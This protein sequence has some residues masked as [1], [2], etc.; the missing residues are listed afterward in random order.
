[1]TSQL[2]WEAVARFKASRI[3]SPWLDAELLLAHVLQKERV[4]LLAHPEYRVNAPQ[5]KQFLLLVRRRSKRIPL[6]HL[7][8]EKEFYG[9]RFRVTPAVLIPR[10]ETEQ[11][12]EFSLPYLKEL[13]GGSVVAD[14]GT[15]S[16]CIA[17]SLAKLLPNL[18]F[19]A[20]D[21]SPDALSMARKN[22]R[23]HG[24]RGR[25]RFLRGPNFSVL[26]KNPTAIIANLPYL[27]HREYASVEPELR[28]EP[29][30]A[31]LARQGGDGLILALLL[32]LQKQSRN[33]NARLPSFAALECGPTR[34]KILEQLARTL[35]P[36]F[37]WQRKYDF[38]DRPRFLF[39]LRRS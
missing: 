1:M 10:P 20:T 30:R 37:R 12:I 7:T 21:I 9:L 16:G 13:P 3:D 22:A 18:R 8:S 6:A 24:V 15:G 27:S 39:A 11:L 19:I 14:I 33:P 29:R 38:A 23:R 2:L 36:M 34:S 31:L 32:A 28:Y 26:K 17:I 25:I 5:R 35:L 4:W